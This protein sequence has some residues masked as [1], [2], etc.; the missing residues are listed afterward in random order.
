M[1]QSFLRSHDDQGVAGFENYGPID[2]TEKA[3]NAVDYEDFSDDDLPE[4]QVATQPL[5][6]AHPA[7]NGATQ[8]SEEALPDTAENVD[9]DHAF[10]ALFGE[11]EA[12]DDL[13]DL[14]GEGPEPEQ[15]LAPVA[16]PTLSLPRLSPQP[17]P[18]RTG[19]ILPDKSAPASRPPRPPPLQTR[20]E[21]VPAN[22]HRSVGDLE[23][24]LREEGVSE[25]DIR[26][27]VMQ[28]KLMEAARRRRDNRHEAQDMEDEE[29]AKALEMLRPLFPRYDEDHNPRFTEI[30]PPRR[31][32][33]R[34]KAPLRPPRPLQVIKPSLDVQADQERSFNSYP[35]SKHA[36]EIG[37]IQDIVIFSDTTDA[38]E[39]QGSDIEMENVDEGKPLAG[40]TMEDF[41]L[42]C[43]SWAVP[44]DSDYEEAEQSRPAKKRRL[45]FATILQEPPRFDQ[46]IFAEPE[47]VAGQLSQAVTLNLNDS[48][49][50]VDERESVARPAKRPLAAVR[51]VTNRYN[52]SNDHAY[53]LLKEN[54]QHKVRSTLGVSTIEH[55]LPARHLQYPFYRVTLDANSKRAFH[56]PALDIKARVD[57]YEFSMMKHKTIKR[58][59]RRGKDIGEL[60]ATSESLSLCDNSSMLLL[61]YSE[62]APMALSNF[63][64]GSRLINYYRKRSSDDAER[65]KR[66]IGET[67]VLLMQDKSPFANF[68]FVDNGEVV[69][70]L[71]NGL[72]RAPVFRH[73]GRHTDFVVGIST[74]YGLGSTF[75]LRNVEN[76]HTVGQQFPLTEVPGR[77]SRRVTDVAKRRLRSIAYR[78]YRK[79]L[80]PTRKDKHL[81]NKTIMKH[82]R[83]LDM[84]QTRSK[85]RDFMHYVKSSNHEVGVWEPT[86]KDPL[87]EPEELKTYI[88]PEEVCLLDS[89]QMGV[90]HL[91]DL[92]LSTGREEDDKDVD[93]NDHIEKQLAP[94]QAT[95]NFIAATQG[96]AML[97]LHGEGDPTGRGEGFSFVKTSMKGGFQMQGESA[98]D[99]IDAKTRKDNGGHSYNVAKQHKAYSELIRQI[100]DRQKASLGSAEEVPDPETEFDPDV[101]R[102]M[103]GRGA[104]P[105]TSM[106]PGGDETATQFSRGSATHREPEKVLAITR[107][108]VDASGKTVVMHDKITNPRVMREYRKRRNE[109]RLK[110]VDISSYEV[111]ED[112]ELNNLV[113][114]KIKEELARVQRNKERRVGREKTKQNKASQAAAGT[115]AEAPLGTDPMGAK[116]PPKRTRNK[117]GT[118]RK[119]AMCGQVGHIKTNRKLC[120]LLNGTAQANGD[121]ALGSVAAPLT[122]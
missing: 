101:E 103:V 58:K 99:K 109:R 27:H 7:V 117:E 95:K 113:Q 50:M 118:A 60:F 23:K 67:Q 56:R 70:T 111:G 9:D 41:S 90:Q 89:M 94:W 11:G 36:L 1:I 68:G 51:D 43:E 83:G 108:A 16:V 6:E 49:L 73:E 34:G 119:C 10:D 64:M 47:R 62:E 18:K 97:T 32:P 52:I 100:W 107:S 28:L 55:S 21:A 35:G 17:A 105:R 45:D 102:S 19:L 116:P 69:P 48:R 44:S 65:P 92:G 115:D 86:S 39:E 12:A 106:A 38:V 37:R 61:E 33:Y 80:D 66:D 57:G 84:P 91:R 71:Q 96:K 13:N 24:A 20:P 85:M 42:I 8:Q 77:N 120:P 79:S 59:D 110:G 76:L 75:T 22:R 40:L 78:I 15:T 3:E 87:P 30:F 2:Q 26:M 112:S 98:E 54:H 53:D 88:K 63:G 114:E 4:E 122:L 93:E 14:F 31:V 5:E 81:D 72:Y 25:K 29:Q 46:I 82:L 104:T 121:N 74:T